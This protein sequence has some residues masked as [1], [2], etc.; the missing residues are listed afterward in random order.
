MGCYAYSLSGVDTVLMTCCGRHGFAAR[1]RRQFQYHSHNKFTTFCRD[2]IIEASCQLPYHSHRESGGLVFSFECLCYYPLCHGCCCCMATGLVA[3]A[4]LLL[5]INRLRKERDKF[6][7]SHVLAHFL[8]KALLQ[9][10]Y[11]CLKR[12]CRQLYLLVE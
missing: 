2:D 1:Q 8:G 3:T 12:A 6:P 7:Y 11:S 10:L 9:F 5:N 4:M